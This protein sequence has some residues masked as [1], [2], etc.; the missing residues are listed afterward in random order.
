MSENGSDN[1]G[2]QDAVVVR[3]AE[4]GWVVGE[5]NV[6]DLTSAMVL[7]DLFAADQARVRVEQAIGVLAER[8]G[9]GRAR[10]STC[11]AVRPGR[12]GRGSPTSPRT[13]WKAPPTRCSGCP[14]S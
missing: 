6:S 13:S 2:E 8:N 9:S 7:A 14:T 12:A 4:R 10:R 11:C 3:K 1:T 5:E